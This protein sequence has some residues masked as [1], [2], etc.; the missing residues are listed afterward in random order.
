MR[1]STG[2]AD[3]SGKGGGLGQKATASVSSIRMVVSDPAYA[4]S[5]PC[6]LPRGDRILFMRTPVGPGVVV[7]DNQSPWELWSVPV[8]GGDPDPVF[9]DPE[10][11]A[12][13]PDCCRVTGRIAFT[14]IR[15]GSA[16]LWILDPAGGAPTRIPVGRSSPAKIFYPCWYPDGRRLVVTDYASHQVLEVDPSAGDVRALTD[17]A[18]VLAGMAAAWCDPAGGDRLAFAGQPP[19]RGFNPS[20]NTVWV[21]EPGREPRVLDGR[22]GRMP[23][24]S[25]TGDRLAFSATRWRVGGRRDPR[26][27][28]RPASTIHVQRVGA[29]LW[30]VGRP[31][32]LTPFRYAAAHGRWSPA[33]TTLACNL[34]R[35][36]G[37]PAGIGLVQVPGVTGSREG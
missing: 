7:S 2:R 37:G 12:T 33:G 27:L 8:G 28:L 24:W 3:G 13:R 23:A 35:R 36:W 25:P 29:A 6:F 15:A 1:T 16:D 34:S 17:P 20:R 22:P 5:R 10:L 21:Q 14:G 9:A 11:S 19:G 18:V 4:Y 32:A 31:H 26:S 30:P